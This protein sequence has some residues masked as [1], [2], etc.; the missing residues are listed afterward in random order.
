MDVNMLRDLANKLMFDMDDDE[1]VTLLKEFDVILKQMDYIND[2]EGI[3]KVD[4]MSSPE[5][6]HDVMLRE[7]DCIDKISTYLALSNVKSVMA[8]QVKVPKVVGISEN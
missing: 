6:V 1:Y 8:N 3:D 2:I 5:I 4:S 7:D